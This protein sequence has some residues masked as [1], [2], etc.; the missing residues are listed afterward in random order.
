MSIKKS[1][2]YLLSDY[3]KIL[4]DLQIEKINCMGK[5]ELLMHI[6][7]QDSWIYDFYLKEK[8]INLFIRTVCLCACDTNHEK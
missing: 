3:N 6:K 7:D 5:D 2:P 4:E 8:C 1:I